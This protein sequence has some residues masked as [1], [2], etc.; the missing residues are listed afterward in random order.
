MTK[1]T[2]DHCGKDVDNF[3]IGTITGDCDF[4]VRRGSVKYK[5]WWT[6][7]ICG[8]TYSA[9]VHEKGAWCGADCLAAWIRGDPV[10]KEKT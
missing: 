1:L 4:S 9:A 5:S 8:H 7:L 2:C 10:T 3:V 6:N